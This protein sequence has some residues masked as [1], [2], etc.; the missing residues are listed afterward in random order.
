MPIPHMEWIDGHFVA[1]VKDATMIASIDHQYH[2][3]PINNMEWIDGRFTPC[4]P[5]KQRRISLHVRI[6]P[7]AH[8]AIGHC[9]PNQQK[10]KHTKST[11]LCLADTGSQAC[12]S[13][14]RILSTLGV[15]SHWLIPTSHGLV[16]ATIISIRCAVDRIIHSHQN[17]SCIYATM[18]QAYIY[19]RKH[20]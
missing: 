13:D 6:L 14:A 7:D 12:V 4:A 15:G 16:C 20:R 2:A 3:S 10:Q 17:R 5:K 9:L 19:Q 11:V 8:A 18:L 1:S